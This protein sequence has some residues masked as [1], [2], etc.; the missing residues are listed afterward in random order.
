VE[1]R[2]RGSSESVFVYKPAVFH[3]RS[4][5]GKVVFFSNAGSKLLDSP[6]VYLEYSGYLLDFQLQFR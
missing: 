3:T 6:I 1:N 5:S 4:P 2:L